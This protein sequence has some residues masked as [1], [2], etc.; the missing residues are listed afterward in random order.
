MFFS[1]ISKSSA[2]N[3]EPSLTQIREMLNS[4]THDARVRWMRET[5]PADQAKL[6]DLAL[7]GETV[8]E[9]L[10][11]SHVPDG[12][13]VVHIGYNSL[14]AFRDFEKR[15]C[16]PHP[17][18]DHLYGYNEGLTRPLIGPGF[19]VV[20]H[21]PERREV[22]VNYYKVPERGSKLDPKWPSVQANEEGLQRFVYANM[23]DYLRKLS[24]HVTIGRAFKHHRATP[25]YF[26][27]CRED[28]H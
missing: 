17:R 15:F 22:G 7:Y 24:D 9:D 21:F 11:P 27:L 5:S 3:A 28:S 20:D 14:P 4:S 13:E 19:F 12:Q 23:I 8:L 2:L 26:L 1:L 18:A 6:W 25:N 10:V 16:R